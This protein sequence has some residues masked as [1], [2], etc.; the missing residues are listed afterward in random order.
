MYAKGSHKNLLDGVESGGATT[1]VGGEK[2]R[3]R[4]KKRKKY[5]KMR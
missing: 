2:R 5:E 1:E 3:K 4:K